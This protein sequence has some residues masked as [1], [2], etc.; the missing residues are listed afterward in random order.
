MKF[1]NY[2]YIALL[3]I[4]AAFGS[5]CASLSTPYKQAMCVSGDC[6][7]GQGNL[8]FKSGTVVAAKFKMGYPQ[9]KVSVTKPNG[10]KYHGH[11]N[12]GIFDGAVVLNS[13]TGQSNVN[14]QAGVPTDL[15]HRRGGDTYTGNFG[16][17]TLGLVDF[18]AYGQ[19]TYKTARGVTYSGNFSYDG[20]HYTFSGLADFGHNKTSKGN[21]VSQDGVANTQALKLSPRGTHY[22]V[23]GAKDYY[24]EYSPQGKKVSQRPGPKSIAYTHKRM[25]CRLSES[26]EGW[27]IWKKGGCQRGLVS[28][29]ST[30]YSNDGSKVLTGVFV[31]GEIT[32]GKFTDSTGMT[33][34]GSW[35]NFLPHGE[36][37]EIIASNKQYRGGFK[38][39]Q[40]HGNGVCTTPERK[41]KCEYDEGT[42]IDQVYVM[43]IENEKRRVAEEAR[44]KE[45]AKQ[46]SAAALAAGGK[47]TSNWPVECI[48]KLAAYKACDQI[49]GFGAM[50]C[51]M[52][53][54]SNFNCNIPM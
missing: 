46:R 8:R 23:I 52:I 39:G 37:H 15:T 12:M 48:K 24:Q 11:M 1:K 50:G 4:M 33:I 18:L 34:N 5:G 3:S 6:M 42:R 20:G 32:K 2:L 19:G 44:Q 51:K 45:A 31:A 36:S 17:D 14:Y 26:G 10:D 22:A 7:A 25:H 43:R 21:F 16:T 30:L 28:G 47:D 35:K 40:R 9:G 29:Q 49:G 54:N 27:F 53:A 13:A 38:N 41:E